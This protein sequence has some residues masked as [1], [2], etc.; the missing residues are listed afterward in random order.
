MNRLGNGDMKIALVNLITRT[1]TRRVVPEIG[2][3]AEAMIVKQALEFKSQGHYVVLYVSDLYQPGNEEDLG[4]RIVYLKTL[5]S[6]FPEIPL[7]PGLIA[8][9][10]NRYDFVVTSEAFQWATIFAVIARLTSWKRKPRIYVWQEL[11]VHQRVL[12]KL[13]S[14]IFHQLVLRFCLD[15]QIAKYIP[16]GLRATLGRA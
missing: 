16:R 12:K 5:L 14:M 2:S 10:R 4:I 7:V 15:W 13:P 11:S 8:Q 1:P 9:L 6:G 3:S